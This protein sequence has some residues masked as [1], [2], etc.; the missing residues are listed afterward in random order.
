MSLIGMSV[1]FAVLITV[2]YDVLSYYYL[3]K[4]VRG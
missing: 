2:F 3:F 1:E 4:K